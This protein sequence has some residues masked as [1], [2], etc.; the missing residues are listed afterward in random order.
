MIKNGVLREGLKEYESLI[1]FFESVPVAEI[2]FK[3]LGLNEI[4]RKIW[5]K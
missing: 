2:P 3:F 5:P 4:W 1:L